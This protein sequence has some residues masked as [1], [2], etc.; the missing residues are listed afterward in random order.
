MEMISKSARQLADAMENN[1]KPNKFKVKTANGR[2]II[3]FYCVSSLDLSS[4]DQGDW[5]T[6]NGYTIF[7]VDDPH[8]KYVLEFN[9]GKQI[10]YCNGKIE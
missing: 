4:C 9:G 10:T 6:V 2:T 1:G 8:I 7:I 5:F 3:P